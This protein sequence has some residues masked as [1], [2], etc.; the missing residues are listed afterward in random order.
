M[1]SYQEM[2]I[3]KNEFLEI[4]ESVEMNRALKLL[5]RV[6]TQNIYQRKI[7]TYR[8]LVELDHFGREIKKPPA[9]DADLIRLWAFAT[10]KSKGLNK[11][12]TCTR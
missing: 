11:K 2:G 8:G 4:L 10:A 9:Q 1:L 3:V 12:I 7:A 5:E 6:L